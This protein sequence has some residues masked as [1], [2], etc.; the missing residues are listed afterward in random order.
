MCIFMEVDD[1]SFLLTINIDYKNWVKFPEF[2]RPSIAKSSNRRYTE[3]V[4]FTTV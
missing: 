3:E 1:L 2:N 4:V